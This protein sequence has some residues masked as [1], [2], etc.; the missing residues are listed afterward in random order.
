MSLEKD[1][2]TMLSSIGLSLYDTTITSEHEEAIYRVSVTSSEGVSMDK[3]VEATKLISPLL[4]VTPPMSG[5]YRLEVSSPGIE[6]KLMTLSHIV[7]SVGE[8]VALT[9]KDKT[10]YRGELLSVNDNDITLRDAESG[11]I[12]VSFNDLNKA[13]TYFEW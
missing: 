5:E 1:I 3:V 11:E 6:R 8:N 4:D 2:K 7:S 12:T 13:K 9:M 10:K